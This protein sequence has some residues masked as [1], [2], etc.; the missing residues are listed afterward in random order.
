[1][2]FR[3][4]LPFVPNG[5][6]V[7]A[8][9]GGANRTVPS[10]MEGVPRCVQ[11]SAVFERHVAGLARRSPLRRLWWWWAFRRFPTL[12][13]RRIA[14]FATTEGVDR[15][16]VHAGW[17]GIPTA[18]QLHR[19]TGLPMHVSVQDDVSGHVAPREGA[20]LRLA[21]EELLSRASTIDVISAPM[22]E[23]YQ[24]RYGLTREP[25]IIWTGGDG[26]PT[27]PP[28]PM[29]HKVRRI[30]YAGNLWA[31]DAMGVLV[32]AIERLNDVR[33]HRDKIVVVIHGARRP[34]A[35][36]GSS[37]VEYRGSVTPEELTR[38]LQTCD[39][40]YVPMSFLPRYELLS[41]TSLPGKL[42]HY[43]QAQVPILAHGPDYAANVRFVRERRVG[44]ASTTQDP[45]QLADAIT[46]IEADVQLRISMS[47]TCR[48]LFETEFSPQATWNRLSQLL[49]FA[50][51]EDQGRHAAT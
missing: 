51:Q 44:F 14:R 18:V 11:A 10:W 32:D 47:R 37:A 35:F 48:H 34:P 27:R 28:P 49:G 2:L 33:D 24:S 4:L 9:A 46:S 29:A 50:Q 26:G 43:M 39:L 45:H 31:T 22:K 19:L 21:F 38:E 36:A 3:A 42:V 41:R 7:W 25:A 20:F 8:V 40:L 6:L 17:S 30:G 23:Y 12:A 1:M 15:M 16:W 13:A 5:R